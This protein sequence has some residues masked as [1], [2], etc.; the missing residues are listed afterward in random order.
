MPRHLRDIIVTEYGIADLRGKSDRDTIA[1]M[2]AVADSAYQPRLIQD[3]QRVGKLERSFAV[4]PHASANTAR[5]LE[6]ALARPGARVCCR[7]SRSAP[8]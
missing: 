2:L 3:A 7:S 1:A 5:R 4:P 6:A 8:R